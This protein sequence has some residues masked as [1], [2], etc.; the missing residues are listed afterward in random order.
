MK[1]KLRE[2]GIKEEDVPMLAS[3]SMKQTRLLQNNMREVT[4]DL[5]HDL[6]SKAW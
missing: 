4:L 1:T 3:E 6:Y 5:A 2:V